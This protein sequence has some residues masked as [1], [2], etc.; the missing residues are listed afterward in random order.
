MHLKTQKEGDMSAINNSGTNSSNSF[1]DSNPYFSHTWSIVCFLFG[2]SIFIS[3]S[4]MSIL[5]ALIIIFSIP[6]IRSVNFKKNK[7]LLLVLFLYPLALFCSLLSATSIEAFKSTLTGWIWPLI[8]LPAFIIYQNQK[9]R[10]YF[11]RGACLGIFI[12]CSYSLFLFVTKYEMIFTKQV[13]VESFWDIGRWGTFLAVATVAMASQFREV[14]TSKQK[15]VYKVCFSI[16]LLMATLCLIL[17]NTRAPWMGALIGLFFL[18]VLKSRVRYSILL[19]LA[20]VISVIS[21]T[22]PLKERFSSIFKIQRTESGKISSS[23][24]SNAGRL[25]MWKV[26]LDLSKENLLW[27]VGFENTEGPLREFLSRQTQEYRDAYTTIEYSY[28]DQHSSY[29]SS[30]LQL[31][32]CFSVLLWLMSYSVLFKS[33][34]SYYNNNLRGSLL[35]PS[36]MICFFVEFFFYTSINTFEATLFFSALIWTWLD[37]KAIDAKQKL[38][39]LDTSNN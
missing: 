31:G 33:I 5:G 25:H 16:L 11:F 20:I 18:I 1:I 19:Y 29:I 34:I 37:S 8:A 22:P 2:L 3:K 35:A 32:L 6:L 4:G 12:G 36:I 23:D 26:A 17:S 7:L 30:L 28:R 10:K 39:N 13:R 14:F 38:D 27:G 15:F 9:L 24:L 21:V